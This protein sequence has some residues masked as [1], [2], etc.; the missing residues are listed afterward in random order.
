M[1]VTYIPKFGE[2][3]DLSLLKKAARIFMLK[4]SNMAAV[5]IATAY[6]IL[7]LRAKI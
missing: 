6:K 3:L 1:L 7:F 5:A 2:Q 4:K